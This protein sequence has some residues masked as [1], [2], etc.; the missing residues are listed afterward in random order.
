VVLANLRHQP[1]EHLPAQLELVRGEPRRPRAAPRVVAR[2]GGAAPD[3]ALQ[4][5][6]KARVVTALR[7]ALT[8]QREATSQRGRET[9]APRAAIAPGKA[10]R[11]SDR[12]CRLHR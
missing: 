7:R 11:M 5:A 3:P 10:A 12:F 8:A 6:E 4:P 9:P 1:L 2:S